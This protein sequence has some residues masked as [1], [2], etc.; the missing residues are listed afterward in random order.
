MIAR[1]E[2]KLGRAF[3]ESVLELQS[4]PQDNVRRFAIVK[5]SLVRAAH[6]YKEYTGRDTLL[7]PY[8]Y[9]GFEEIPRDYGEQA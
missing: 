5:R 4:V 9:Y 3:I 7:H 6:R 8:T 2:R 1:I